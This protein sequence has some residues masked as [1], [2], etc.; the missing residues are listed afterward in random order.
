MKN[1]SNLL[2]LTKQAASEQEQ[3]PESSQQKP[4]VRE[5]TYPN[6]TV[7]GSGPWQYSPTTDPMGRIQT[8]PNKE[9]ITNIEEL[10]ARKKPIIELPRVDPLDGLSP[11]STNIDFD[12][13]NK[14]DA[15][16]N[17]FETWEYPT[18]DGIANIKRIPI[19]DV[20]QEYMGKVKDSF[21]NKDN[22]QPAIPQQVE[23]K[24]IG[25]QIWDWIKENPGLAGAGAL[26]LSGLGYYLLKDDE[27]EEE[28]D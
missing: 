3:K 14:M 15:P 21:K 5:T 19:R 25:T 20:V 28:E 17:L 26:G 27:D 24:G 18:L 12:K 2:Q 6:G 10:L 13:I 1:L 4:V 22:P 16:K 23:E 9:V 8:A 11:N 7:I